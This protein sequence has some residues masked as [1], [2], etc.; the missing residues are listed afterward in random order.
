MRHL[1]LAEPPAIFAA[2]W[3]CVSP[4]IAPSTR[5]K[6]DFCRGSDVNKIV[7]R[8]NFLVPVSFSCGCFPF[9]R[10]ACQLR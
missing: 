8:F 6:I 2:L 5:E 3:R 9:Q 10:A 7:V 1:W 4:L